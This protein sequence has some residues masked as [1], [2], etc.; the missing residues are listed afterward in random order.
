M[1]I[2]SY[3]QVNI[4][5]EDKNSVFN[6]LS[7][8]QFTQLP[9]LINISHLNE[10]YSALKNIEQYFME[11]DIN[12]Y[13][14]PIYIIS[15]VKNY[16][17]P[18]HIFDSVESCPKFFKQKIKQLNTKENKIL[19]KIYLKQKN[20]KNMNTLNHKEVFELYSESHKKIF[21]LEKE[22]TFLDNLTDKL[23][24]HFG[25]IDEQ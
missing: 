2:P 15:T 20:L 17:G 18:F 19:Q 24:I 8:H 7:L 23:N 4:N 1:A 12:N 10:Q 11:N 25:K 9:Y 13:P 6:Q 16:F 5:F 14:Y 21:Y 3:K 22:K